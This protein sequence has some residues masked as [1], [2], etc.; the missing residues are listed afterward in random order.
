MKT[1][2]EEAIEDIINNNKIQTQTE[3]KDKLASEKK[4]KISQATLSRELQNLGITKEDGYY[5][6]QSEEE[7]ESEAFYKTLWKGL[8]V[9]VPKNHVSF[10]VQTKP[11]SAALLGKMIEEKYPSS[12]LG[13]IPGENMLQVVV[14][15]STRRTRMKERL[16]KLINSTD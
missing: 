12:V 6:G 4:I 3:L 2:I 13:C 14:K 5:T 16:Q 11:G 1:K 7:R 8:I 9:D 15:N 10:Y